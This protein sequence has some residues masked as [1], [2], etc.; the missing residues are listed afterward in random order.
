VR[1]PNGM[2]E[3]FKELTSRDEQ[4]D[5][6]NLK[7]IIGRITQEYIGRFRTLLEQAGQETNEAELREAVNDL[8]TLFAGKHDPELFKRRLEFGTKLGT[9]EIPLEQLIKV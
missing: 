5:F 9:A 7:E 4:L 3:F 1:F 6:D 8:L 2:L